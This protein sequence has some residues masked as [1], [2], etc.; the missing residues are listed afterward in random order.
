ML[1]SAPGVDPIVAVPLIAAL[2]EVGQRFRREV[3]AR[4]GGAPFNHDSGQRRVQRGIWGGRAKLRTTLYMPTLVAI[5]FNPAIH[6]HG[7]QLLHRG[8]PKMVA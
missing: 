3:A 5:R 6:T 8:K 7:E 1:C 4:G 2:P